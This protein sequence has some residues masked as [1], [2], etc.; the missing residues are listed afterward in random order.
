MQGCGSLWIFGLLDAGLLGGEGGSDVRVGAG[1]E[2]RISHPW[3]P[4]RLI[5]YI[6]VWVGQQ[7]QSVRCQG[8]L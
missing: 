7:H 2:G 4:A 1:E 3:Q 6:S 5:G 8:N